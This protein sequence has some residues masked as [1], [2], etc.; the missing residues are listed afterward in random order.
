MTPGAEIEPGPHWW[1]AS[2]LT[3]RP[4]LPPYSETFCFSD[5]LVVIQGRRIIQTEA[6]RFHYKKKQQH[7]LALIFSISFQH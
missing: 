1:K 3:T 5:A 4:T 6:R 2:A 7:V